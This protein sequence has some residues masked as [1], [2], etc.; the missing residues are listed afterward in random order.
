ME[1][2]ETLVESPRGRMAGEQRRLARKHAG[3]PTH[4]VEHTDTGA[5]TRGVEP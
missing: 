1:S 2:R 4:S 3:R 5:M